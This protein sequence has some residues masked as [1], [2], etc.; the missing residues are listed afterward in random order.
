[1]GYVEGKNIAIEYRYADDKFDR[2][3]ALGADLV[4]LK[5]DVIIAPTIAEVLAARNA[6]AVIPIV[7]YNVPD[8][9]RRWAGRKPF[10]ARRA[11]HRVHHYS[12]G[13]GGQKT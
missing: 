11:Y 4:R 1:M 5:V 6:T 12:D 3:P 2:L 7:F 8:P 9:G 13:F 10:S